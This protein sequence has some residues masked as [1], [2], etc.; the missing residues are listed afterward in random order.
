MISERLKRVIL[1]ELNL[2]DVDVAETTTARDIPGWD[3]LAHVR[4]I[5]AVEKAFGVRFTNLEVMRLSTISEL[6]QL[7]DSK[8]GR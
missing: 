5:F 8:A 7:V 4:I 2:G 1:D 3:S 6:Q